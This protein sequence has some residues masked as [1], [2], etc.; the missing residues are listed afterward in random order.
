MSAPIRDLIVTFSISMGSHYAEYHFL[1]YM[2]YVIDVPLSNLRSP[3][4]T[5]MST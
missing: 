4:S 1:A 3:L 5:T 2:L